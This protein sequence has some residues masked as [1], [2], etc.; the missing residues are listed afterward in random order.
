MGRFR[1]VTPINSHRSLTT[2]VRTNTSSMCFKVNGLGVHSRSTGRFAVSSLHRV[3]TAYGRRN[4][5][6][7]LAIGAIVCSGSVPAVG[8][9]VSTTGRTNVSTI[10]TDSITIVDCY[11]RMKRRI[12]LSARLG[13]SGARTLGF[14]T[15]FTSIS[16][17]THRL[18]VSRI[19]RVRRRV[20]GRGVYNPVNGR[21]HVRVFYRNTLY[22][23][24]SNG[25]CVDLTGTGH[26]TGHNRYIRVYHHDCAIASGRANGRLRVSGG[27]MVDPGSLGAVHFVSHVVSTNIHIFGVRN[28]THKPRC[29]CAMIGYCGRTV[30]TMLSNAFARR[31]GSR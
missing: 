30:T 25:Y 8:R 12:R 14:C 3:T 15:H 27:C 20:R 31:G 9:V 26:S 24:M 16:I 28:H 18:G 11:G 29:M 1:I 21:V 4:V 5:G 23:T 13:V 10:V 2:T 22:V 7:C 17:L 6:A 19:G